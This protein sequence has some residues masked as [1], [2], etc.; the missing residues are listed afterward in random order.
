MCN[1]PGKIQSND[2]KT[3]LTLP[4]KFIITV[5]PLR[6]TTPL[7]NI[8]RGVLLWP[9][10]L[11]VSATPSNSF[12]KISFVASGVKSRG[13]TPVPPVVMT[14]STFKSSE[15]LLSSDIIVALLS[16]ITT[17]STI[18]HP[19]PFNFSIMILPDSS[20]CLLLVSLAT[21]TAALILLQELS[22]KSLMPP[23]F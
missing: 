2:S 22:L 21:R 13:P 11:I 5:F 9:W 8:D 1:I 20:S 14:I 19:I 17:Y 4:G 3:A 18:L 6:P 7:D 10:A 16:G 12:S 23:F 15:N